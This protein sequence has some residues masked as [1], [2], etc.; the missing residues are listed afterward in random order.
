LGVG[1][2]FV[3]LFFV[4]VL[5]HRAILL[6]CNNNSIILYIPQSCLDKRVLIYPIIVICVK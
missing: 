4:Y 2:V 6:F 1:R 3:V 5:T